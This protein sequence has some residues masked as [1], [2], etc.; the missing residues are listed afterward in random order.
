[1]STSVLQTGVCML[2]AGGDASLGY[3]LL[4]DCRKANAPRKLTAESH[5][6]VHIRIAAWLDL[7]PTNPVS[8][9]WSAAVFR[10]PVV[11]LLLY[12]STI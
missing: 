8:L 2:P 9:L 10:T 4:C 12:T 1:V 5:I 11:L 3:K 7:R 6:R